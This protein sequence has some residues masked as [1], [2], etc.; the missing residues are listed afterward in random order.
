[1]RGGSAHG[2]GRGLAVQGRVAMVG[3]SMSEAYWANGGCTFTRG[4]ACRMHTCVLNVLNTTIS[5]EILAIHSALASACL[6]RHRA[7]PRP[8]SRCGSELVGQMIAT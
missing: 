6:I 8:V 2:R 1:M 5:W 4:M 3:S 7:L